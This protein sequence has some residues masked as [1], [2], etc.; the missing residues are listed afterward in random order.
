MNSLDIFTK[1]ICVVTYTDFNYLNKA[2]KT[3]KDIRTR[4]QF[5]GSLV[6][7]TDGNFKINDDYIKEM[8]IIVKEYPDIDTSS[9]IAKIKEHPF[10]QSDG[11]E[12]LKLKQWNKLYVFDVFFKQ[13]DFIL[14]V[15]AGLRIFDRIEF[16][17]FQFRKNAIVAMDDAYPD[18][19]KNFTSQIELSNTSVVDKLKKFYNI[20]S[21][22]FLNCIFLFDTNIIKD[23]TLSDLID[24]MNEY[25]ICKTNE[26]AIMN[27]YFAK[28]WIP[29]N[30][31]LRN[32]IL[33]DWSER[34]NRIWKDY[35]SLKYPTTYS[36]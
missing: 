1:N 35:I 24:L 21:K 36:D 14:F 17:Y 31:Y 15:D 26:M 7:I 12:Y 18:Y 25:P 10:I 22:Y 29:M 32:H 13:W 11:R 2:E 4:G 3:I 5:L 23:N 27:I 20:E 8:K 28:L 9:L 19:T 16:F 34:D 33:F 6:V 30:I